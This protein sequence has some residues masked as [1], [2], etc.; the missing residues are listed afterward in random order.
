M[1][2]NEDKCIV[3]KIPLY[4]YIQS[5]DNNTADGYYIRV[6]GNEQSDVEPENLWSSLSDDEILTKFKEAGI[7]SGSCSNNDYEKAKKLIDVNLEWDADRI[8][9]LLCKYL[10]F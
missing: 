4:I 2:N 9:Q 3:Q 8:I 10:N 5:S 7:P 6:P 1:I